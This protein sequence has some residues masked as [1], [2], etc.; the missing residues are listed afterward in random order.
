MR[1][2]LALTVI[3]NVLS[4]NAQVAAHV[5]LIHCSHVDHVEVRLACSRHPQL[6][7]IL[8]SLTHHVGGFHFT[9]SHFSGRRPP[10]ELS[11]MSARVGFGCG[12]DSSVALVEESVLLSLVFRTSVCQLHI[13]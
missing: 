9:R 8:L 12:Y 2:D 11:L 5:L 3:V 1:L 6:V 13:A 7:Q 10:L 4:L